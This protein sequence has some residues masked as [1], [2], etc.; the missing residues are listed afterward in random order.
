MESPTLLP[1]SCGAWSGTLL[2]EGTAAG[3]EAVRRRDRGTPLENGPAPARATAYDTHASRRDSE[4][5][6]ENSML[7][8]RTWCGHYGWQR[9]IEEMEYRL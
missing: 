4:R 5:H 2:G 6:Q 3:P 8:S 7:A 9:A 1:L